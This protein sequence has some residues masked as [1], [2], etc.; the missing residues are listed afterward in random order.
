MSEATAA[1]ARSTKNVRPLKTSTNSCEE[2]TDALASTDALRAVEM[3][4]ENNSTRPQQAVFPDVIAY[5][6]S[7]EDDYSCEMEDGLERGA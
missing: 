6:N 2:S 5:A 7:D 4:K 3:T 1:S